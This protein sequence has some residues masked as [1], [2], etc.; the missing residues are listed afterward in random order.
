MPQGQPETTA[1]DAADAAEILRAITRISYLITRARRHDRVRTAAAVPLDRAAVMVL[2]QL[3]EAGR[4]R[5]GELAA[6]LGVEAPHV[7]RQVQRL[8]KAG[9]TQI[10]SRTRTTAAPTSSSSPPQARQH[11]T[12]SARPAKPAC[13]PP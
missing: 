9:D 6:R 12:A 11:P 1:A 13:R 7:T 5:P 4:M 3:A 2:G 10:V 8:Q